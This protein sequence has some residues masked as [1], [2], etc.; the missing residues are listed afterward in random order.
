[1]I[2]LLKRLIDKITLYIYTRNMCLSFIPYFKIYLLGSLI[3]SFI[4]FKLNFDHI[5]DD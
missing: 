3:L 4:N 2:I 1:M 5:I